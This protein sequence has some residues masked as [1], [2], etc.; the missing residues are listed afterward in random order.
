MLQR[1]FL[2]V[3]QDASLST[4]HSDQSRGYKIASASVVIPFLW[5][6][7]LSAQENVSTSK[8]PPSSA[9]VQYIVG[10]DHVHKGTDGVLEFHDGDI[11]FT[12]GATAEEIRRDQLEDSFLG[13]ERAEKG[14]TA[15]R[16]AR[17]AVPYGGGA[18][19]GA[20]SEKEVGILTI[21]FRDSTGGLHS[22]VFV[23]KKA[24][25]V[26]WARTL[27]Q[28]KERRRSH[29]FNQNCQVGIIPGAVTIAEIGAAP[30]ISLP[31][32]YR[33]IMY[34]HL[35][36][37]SEDK[38]HTPHLIRTGDSSAACAPLS[39]SL[40]VVGLSCQRY[41]K[42][43]R[44]GRLKIPQLRPYP[45]ILTLGGWDGA[46]GGFYGDTAASSRWGERQRDRP[47]A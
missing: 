18:V 2:A 45:I 37:L 1:L 11:S 22:A 8:N 5:I 23:T 34:E 38:T 7:L 46:T 39:L 33:A 28:I 35:L 26:E 4:R 10:F 27:Q 42:I 19:L 25:A 16:V 6:A 21:D 30:S 29:D 32:E 13:T 47:A 44:I 17:F 14:G 3:L 36:S 43:P 41:L 31:E 40:R 24:D 15:G 12:N 9:K 20:V